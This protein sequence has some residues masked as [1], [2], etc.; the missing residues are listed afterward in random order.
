MIEHTTTDKW[1][2][3]LKA[4]RRT[5]RVIRRYP[6]DKAL[7]SGLKSL[8]KRKAQLEKESREHEQ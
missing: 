2:D 3:T 5:K 1:I 6:D 4:I 8:L 7:A